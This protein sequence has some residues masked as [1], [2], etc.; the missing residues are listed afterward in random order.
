MF[1]KKNLPEESTCLVIA[2]ATIRKF[3]QWHFTIDC[4]T[5][6]G[7]SIYACPVK[8]SPIVY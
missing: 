7:V 8:S 4:L 1:F 5:F 3:I 6:T 2:N